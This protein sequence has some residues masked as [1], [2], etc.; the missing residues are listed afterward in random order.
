MRTEFDFS[1]LF[2]STVGFDRMFNLLQHAARSGADENY[3]PYDID[4]TDE[5]SYRVTLAVAGFRPEE[6]NV[7]AQQNLL[8]ITGERRGRDDAHADQRRQALYRGIAGRSFER[9]FELADHVKVVGADL[10]NG[11]LVID[12]KREVPEEMRPRRIEIG[13]SNVLSGPQAP[14]QVEGEAR[15]A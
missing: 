8:I 11:L 9:R 3:P 13:G 2:R 10:A 7:V 4:R 6:L 5:D 15:A 1:P 12:L 14:R